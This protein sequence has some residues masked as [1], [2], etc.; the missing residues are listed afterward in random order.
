MVT[1]TCNWRP[2]FLRTWNRFI[3]VSLSGYR[4]CLQLLYL[5]EDTN[6]WVTV[7]ILV[8]KQSNLLAYFNPLSPCS[9]TS[10]SRSKIQE[11]P[12]LHTKVN[13]AGLSHTQGYDSHW[14]KKLKGKT[15]IYNH[16]QHHQ[17]SARVHFQWP[18]HLKCS[19]TLWEIH[20]VSGVFM[21]PGTLSIMIHTSVRKL[22]SH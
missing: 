13:N 22:I 14:K 16:N 2:V 11:C 6:L 17:A 9:R 20:H 10:S 7:V 4:V 15:C 8:V 5:G 18:A 21:P 1:Q 3:Q 12:S 19:C